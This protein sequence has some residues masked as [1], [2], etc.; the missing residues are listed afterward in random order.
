MGSTSGINGRNVILCNSDPQKP[1]LFL[2]RE[3]V[4]QMII[5]KRLKAP[6]HRPF[7]KHFVHLGTS[8]SP[9]PLILAKCYQNNTESH[10]KVS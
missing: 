1:A 6:V 4:F 10:S 9:K 7:A 5:M 2:R 3:R 8:G